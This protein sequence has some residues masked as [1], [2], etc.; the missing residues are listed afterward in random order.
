MRINSLVFSTW[1]AKNAGDS[2]QKW[3]MAASL[4]WFNYNLRMSCVCV[5]FCFRSDNLHWYTTISCLMWLCANNKTS[6]NPCD[7][8]ETIAHAWISQWNANVVSAGGECDAAV[9]QPE[10]KK[11]LKKWSFTASYGGSFV[12]R[13]CVF[14]S[15]KMMIVHLSIC[16]PHEFPRKSHGLRSYFVFFVH[17]SLRFHCFKTNA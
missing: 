11:R 9:Q 3:P 1:L 8:R 15:G 16:F 7:T 13:Q 17:L 5:F 6:P 2:N 4:N 10:G 12:C 14:S